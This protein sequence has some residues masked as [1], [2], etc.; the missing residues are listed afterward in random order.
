MN[1]VFNFFTSILSI[2]QK[3]SRKKVSSIGRIDEEYDGWLGI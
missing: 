3:S 1:K 2:F